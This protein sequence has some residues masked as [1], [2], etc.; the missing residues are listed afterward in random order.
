MIDLTRA[1]YLGLEHPHHSLA[2]WTALTSGRPA[3]LGDGHALASLRRRLARLLGFP[4]VTLA[5]STLHVVTDLYTALAERVRH[6]H[7][8]ACTYAVSRWGL[9]HARLR[10][11]AV[12]PF[13][14]L[15]ELEGQLDAP[16]E[17]AIVCDA[18]C[19]ACRRINPLRSLQR[20]AARSRGWLIV[21]DSQGVGLLGAGPSRGT[22]YGRGGGGT[23]RWCAAPA[24]RVIAIG[25]LAKGFGAPVAFLAA[26]EA[27]VGWFERTSGTRMHSSP[28][29][30]A[31]LGAL[32]AALCVND[33]RGDELRTAVLE[34][35][36]RFRAAVARAGGTLSA[37]RF[38]VQSTPPLPSSV[39]QT[40]DDRLRRRGVRVFRLRS[41]DG[42]G[43]LGFIVTAT[44]DR[45]EIEAAGAIVGQEL[46]SSRLLLRSDRAVRPVEAGARAP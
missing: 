19:I 17:H 28:C 43:R 23:L 34:R 3:V 8:D 1:L 2:P 29:N 33:H 44:H 24:E 31:E 7:V 16:G 41:Q 39:A 9:D 25:S 5:P 10:G 21:D 40:V 14:T 12:Q 46:A 32:A 45:E 18:I 22:P 38:P 4:R 6:L 26:S 30:A 27:L 15:H 35:V 42:A 37:G 20:L 11:V 13:Q 36:D